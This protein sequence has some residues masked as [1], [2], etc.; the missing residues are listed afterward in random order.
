M[1]SAEDYINEHRT[2][3]FNPVTV[4]HIETI[5]RDARIQGLRDAVKMLKKRI[6]DGENMA[7]MRQETDDII[8]TLRKMAIKLKEQSP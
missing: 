6:G 5:Q 3:Y 1:K 2:G 4:T 8:L 7:G